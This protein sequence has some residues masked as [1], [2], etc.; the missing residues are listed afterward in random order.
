MK[1][2]S[3]ILIFT[4]ILNLLV[5]CPVLA[6]EK[7][8]Q[9]TDLIR[10]KIEQF[11]KTDISSKSASVQSIYKRTL[12]RLYS[13]FNAALQQDIADL[14]AMQSAVGGTNAESQNEIAKQ[15]QK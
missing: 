12:L 1:P 5:A 15:I 14:K 3:R 6:Q 11:E 13:Q 8:S 2:L 4:L 9:D 7:Q 10:A